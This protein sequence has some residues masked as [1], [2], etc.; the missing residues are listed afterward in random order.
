[1]TPPNFMV[2]SLQIGKLH[3]G[4]ESPLA[5]PDSEKPG[6]FRIN[7]DI[8]TRFSQLC[9]VRACFG[10]F[11]GGKHWF[12]MVSASFRLFWLVLGHSAFQ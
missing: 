8:W 11:Q 7:M 1:M 6:L 10:W 2:I 12:L 9:M 4:A 5:L 3:M